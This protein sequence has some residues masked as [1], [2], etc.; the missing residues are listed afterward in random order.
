ML[1]QLTKKLVILL[2][3]LSASRVQ[4]IAKINID[5]IHLGDEEVTIYIPS[6]LKSTKPSF[7]QQPILL[8]HYAPNPKLSITSCLTEYLER[9]KNIRENLPGN[10]KNLIL[11]YAY[12]HMPVSSSTIARYAKSFLKEA[13]IDIKVF[14][15]HSTR[16]SSSSKADAAGLSLVNICKAAG[17]K[18]ESTFRRFY[19]LP[20]KRENFGQI[21]LKNV[22]PINNTSQN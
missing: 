6:L 19:Q 10:P 15:A 2:C 21:I 12:P 7:H 9:T 18:T 5:Y 4:T 20:V 11:S 22:Q 1:E 17:W 14:S 16:A 3:L 8:T 13:G